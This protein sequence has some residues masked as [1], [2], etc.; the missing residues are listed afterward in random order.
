[1]TEV[2][3][4]SVGWITRA[5]KELGLEENTV[6]IFFSDN[7]TILNTFISKEMAANNYPLRNGKGTLYEGGIRVPL[8]IKWPNVVA[9]GSVSHQLF[10]SDDFFPTF[11]QMAG[12]NKNPDQPLDGKSIVSLLKGDRSSL[13]NELFFHFPAYQLLTPSYAIREGDF[14]LIEFFEDNKVELYNLQNDL[15]EKVNLAD[16]MPDKV[17]RLRKKWRAWQQALN[18]GLPREN[19][20]YDFKKSHLWGERGYGK[21]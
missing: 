1:M 5:V 2:L 3:D 9:K 7:G 15:G 21:L 18:A 17:E 14:K 19:P 12:I 6:V 8:I 16:T 10:T 11:L 20:D 13:R 4:E